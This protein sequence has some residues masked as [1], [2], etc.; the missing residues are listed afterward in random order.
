MSTDHNFNRNRKI[1]LKTVCGGY[2]LCTIL[3]ISHLLG[4]RQSCVV[5]AQPWNGLPHGW[6]PPYIEDPPH[7]WVPLYK[8]TF[9]YRGATI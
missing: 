9:V 7:G 6:G 4:L 2:L 1:Q 3:P 8:E 5:D